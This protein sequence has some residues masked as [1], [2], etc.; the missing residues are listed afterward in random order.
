MLPPEA[1]QVFDDDRF[2]QSL[3]AVLVHADKIGAVEI[4]ARI[5]VV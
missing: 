4:C 2:D 3:F 1:A 5:T